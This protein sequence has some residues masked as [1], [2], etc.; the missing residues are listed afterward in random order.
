MKKSEFSEGIPQTA[1]KVGLYNTFN[2]EIYSA[3][4]PYRHS[5]KNLIKY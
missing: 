1:V 5:K 2:H 4:N 3:C